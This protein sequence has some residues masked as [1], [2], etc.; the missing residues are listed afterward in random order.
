MHRHEP[1][2]VHCVSSVESDRLCKVAILVDCFDFCGSVLVR[3]L[4]RDSDFHVGLEVCGLNSNERMIHVVHALT[5]HSM[6]TTMFGSLL[7]V[8]TRMRLPTF[9][10]STLQISPSQVNIA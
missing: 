7:W 10:D 2:A 3:F 9:G 8:V 5:K 6:W 1:Q 4:R